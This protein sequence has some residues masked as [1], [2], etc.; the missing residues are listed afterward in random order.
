[1]L[2]S[3]A[4]PIE[5]TE[6]VKLIPNTNPI[7]L[8]QLMSTLTADDGNARTFAFTKKGLVR[9]HTET[10]YETKWRK[11]KLNDSTRSFLHDACMNQIKAGY[12]A[13]ESLGKVYIAE[14]FYKVG[15]P[16]NTSASGK[17]I[18]VPATGTRL[19][20]TGTKIRSFVHWE[21]VRDIDSS[22][23]YEMADG[24]IEYINFTN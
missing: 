11:S 10:D 5:A 18:D 14:N 20:I 21:D 13:Q 4:N 22:T 16:V 7:V 6:I 3:R 1:M 19:P 9:K 17:G 12:E 2:I 24:K 8:Y 15:V 23:I